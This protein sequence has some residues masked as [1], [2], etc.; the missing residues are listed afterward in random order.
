ML[1]WSVIFLIG[2]PAYIGLREAIRPLAVSQLGVL[3]VSLLLGVVPVAVFAWIFKGA[4]T[5]LWVVL[6]FV[7]YLIGAWCAFNIAAFFKRDTQWGWA[8]GPQ[9]WL[10]VTSEYVQVLDEYRGQKF[11]PVTEAFFRVATGR[12]AEGDWSIAPPASREAG[13]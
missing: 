13:K 7:C 8:Y 6:T 9:S 3:G 12:A 11:L 4:P 10:Y 2:T 5:G 1:I